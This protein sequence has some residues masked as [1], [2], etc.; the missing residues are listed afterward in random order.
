[1]ANTLNILERTLAQVLDSTNDLHTLGTTNGRES[2]YEPLVVRITDHA[3][4]DAGETG[5]DTD[6]MALFVSQRHGE[7]FIK[8]ANV[9]AH[10]IHSAGQGF[11]GT[12]TATAGVIDGV[13]IT[14]GGSGYSAG[15]SN[16]VIDGDAGGNADAVLTPTVVDGEITAIAI[17]GGGTGYTSGALVITTTAPTDASILYPDFDYTTFE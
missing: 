8:D 6:K 7:P 10:V 4:N 11:A 15:Y 3:D 12:F 5:T 16:I 9:L 17:T 2:V 14:D 1:M 13:T